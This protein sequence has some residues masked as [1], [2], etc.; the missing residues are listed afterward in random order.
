MRNAIYL[1]LVLGF[2]PVVSVSM[3]SSS[4]SAA[5][6][7]LPNVVVIMADDVGLSDISYHVRRFMKLKPVFETPALDALAERGMWFTD[8]HSA[9]SL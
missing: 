5:S 3:T 4:V 9:T 7:S 8:G 2:I 1:F 6:S